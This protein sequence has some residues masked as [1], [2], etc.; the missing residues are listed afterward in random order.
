M[1]EEEEGH[2]LVEVDVEVHNFDCALCK[3]LT[4]RIVKRMI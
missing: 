4:L 1:E 2:D 3:D